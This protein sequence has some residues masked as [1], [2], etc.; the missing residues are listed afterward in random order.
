M[1]TDW[2]HLEGSEPLR[3]A[4]AERLQPTDPNLPVRVTV[5]VRGRDEAGLERAV[6]DLDRTPPSQRTYLSRD[7]LSARYGA[8]PA[9]L[10]RVADFYRSQGLQLVEQNAGRRTVVLSGPASAVAAA[11][12]VGFSNYRHAAGTYR[13]LDG[14]VSLPTDLGGIVTAVLGLDERPQAATRHI[15]AQAATGTA[16]PPQQVGEVYAFPTSAATAG[17]T[18]GI[19]ELGGGYQQSDLDSFFRSAGVA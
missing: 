14:P 13:G 1:S 6:Q 18:V 16:F 8:D 19:V 15:V 7:E 12:Q 5:V 11:F 9:D 3:P 4:G 17:Q 2:V 10:Q